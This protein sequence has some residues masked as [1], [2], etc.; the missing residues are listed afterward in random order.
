MWKYLRMICAVVAAIAV[1]ASVFIAIYLGMVP[2][3]ATLAGALLFFALSM[4]FKF[5]QEEREKD[6]GDEP[7]DTDADD[8]PATSAAAPA[9]AADAEKEGGNNAEDAEGAPRD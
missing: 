3:W 6:A 5:L 8:A 9:R 7:N 4:L 1:A 2:F